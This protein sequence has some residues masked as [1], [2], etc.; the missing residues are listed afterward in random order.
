MLISQVLTP[1]PAQQ[2]EA[3]PPE[4]T[5]PTETEPSQAEQTQEA[6]DAQAEQSAEEP[7]TAQAPV[8][9]APSS[10]ESSPQSSENLTLSQSAESVAPA[11][12][13]PSIDLSEADYRAFAEAA[14]ARDK[15]SDGGY[16]QSLFG[17]VDVADLI[18]PPPQPPSASDA[19]RTVLTD[20]VE[21]YKAIGDY[22]AAPDKPL[23]SV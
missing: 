9:A 5:Q 15:V 12:E 18:G 17:S 4:D 20:A 3:P 16:I 21:G 6:S 11:A 8:N 2:P 7:A 22:D 14:Q 13:T 23:E 19:P 1:P 10:A